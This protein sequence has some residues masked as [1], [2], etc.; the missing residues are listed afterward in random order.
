MLR[1]EGGEAPGR[2]F[3][4]WLALGSVGQTR[5]GTYAKIDGG[6]RA[7][8]TL[9]ISFGARKFRCCASTLGWL[10]AH[11]TLGRDPLLHRPAVRRESME[12]LLSQWTGQLQLHLGRPVSLDSRLF[13]SARAV[14]AVS[15]LHRL[16][17]RGLGPDP[18][19]H[20]PHLWG[21]PVGYRLCQRDIQYEPDLRRAK[22]LHS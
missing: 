9:A 16:P 6:G 5:E 19:R 11:G 20:W 12:Y 2:R 3:G 1:P 18:A 17:H 4:C 10:L 22:S 21:K 8:S 15:G 14:S 7:G 13:I